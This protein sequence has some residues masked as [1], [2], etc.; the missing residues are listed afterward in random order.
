MDQQKTGALIAALRKEL[1]LTQ[2][3]LADRLSLSDRT[4]KAPFG[5][6]S[7]HGI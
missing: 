2:R 5:K 4:N 3:E 7:C 6:G 1:G